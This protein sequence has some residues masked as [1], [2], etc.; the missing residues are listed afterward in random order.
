MYPSLGVEPLPQDTLLVGTL[1]LAK[2]LSVERYA[3]I[4]AMAAVN[5]PR[6]SG[7]GTVEL[8]ICTNCRN[9]PSVICDFVDT[10]FQLRK[11]SKCM[12][13]LINTFIF[14]VNEIETYV[15]R[16]ENSK[17]NFR[18]HRW[19]SNPRQAV[20]SNHTDHCTELVGTRVLM[21]STQVC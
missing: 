6:T 19:D 17:N 18:V 13:V 14:L 10:V 15:W 8:T 20:H 5:F 3:S 1:P 4:G 11:V 16:E 7:C 21:K 9:R 12:F 2:A